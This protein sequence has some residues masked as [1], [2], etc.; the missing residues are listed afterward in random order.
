MPAPQRTS[1]GTWGNS[2]FTGGIL[3]LPTLG[4]ARSGGTTRSSLLPWP[5]IH[6]CGSLSLRGVKRVTKGV[7]L[8]QTRVREEGTRRHPE[9]PSHHHGS[10]TPLIAAAMQLMQRRKSDGWK[11][12]YPVII[13]II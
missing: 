8:D 12:R 1:L 3:P 9:L 2:R 7:E 10:G 6:H 13:I 5:A 4:V 11:G